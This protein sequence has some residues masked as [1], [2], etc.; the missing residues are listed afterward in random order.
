MIAK[1]EFGRT[2]YLS[3]RTLFGAAA[4]GAVSQEEADQTFELLFKYGVNHIDTAA[5]Y[6]DAELR[7]GPWMRTHRKDFFLATKTGERSYEKAKKE[8]HQS[9]ERLQTDQ[10]DL[11]QLHNLID[12]D[13]WALAMGDTGALKA[14]VEAKE[15]GL[16]RFIGVTGH[17]LY[18]PEIHL[19]SL[20]V[21]DFD[22]VLLP[23]N[24]MLMQ[25]E[26]YAADFMK[27]YTTCKERKVAIQLIKTQQRRPWGDRKHDR[28]TWYEPFEDQ[29]AI[30]LA[31]HW[32]LALDGV[33]VNT[34]GDIHILPR[35]LDA[36]SRFTGEQPSDTAMQKLIE[37][38]T[39]EPL[40]A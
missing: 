40:W 2:N 5:S 9:L 23:Y 15:Q 26:Q 19:K 24:F 18:A 37:A 12:D 39:A 1:L 31:T 36:A 14:A 34:L 6:G 25:N 20:G 27:L 11:I 32:A 21:Y 38:Q 10:I 13:E 33:F 29:S 8:I 4:L 16:V 17:T 30:D 7:V 22:S 28:S 3:T 35:M